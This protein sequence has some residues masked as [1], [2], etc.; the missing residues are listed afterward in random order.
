M[1]PDKFP[2]EKKPS[3]TPGSLK[4]SPSSM[5]QLDDSGCQILAQVRPE[6]AATGGGSEIRPTHQLIC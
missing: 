2:M 1:T 4:K 6:K 5:A 3:K